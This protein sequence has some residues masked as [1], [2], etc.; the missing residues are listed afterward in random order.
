MEQLARLRSRIATVHELGQIIRAMRSLAAMRVQQAQAALPGIRKYAAIAGNAIVSVLPFAALPDVPRRAGGGRPRILVAFC[1]EHG[2][3]G[4][5]NDVLLARAARET[6]ARPTLLFLLGSRGADMADER[7]LKVDWRHAMATHA[8]GVLGVT[9]RLTP[10]LYR[11]LGDGGPLEVD[12]LFARYSAGAQW[13]VETLRLLPPD[14]SAFEAPR[15]QTPLHNLPAD[16]LVAKLVEEYVLAEL[17]RVAMESLA[18][19]NGARLRAMEE[20]NDNVAALIERLQRTEHQLRQDEITTE[21]LDVV[22]GTTAQTG[23]ET[24]A[25]V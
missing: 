23:I 22:T 10:A 20:A 8:G 2:F 13:T 6:A 12:L 17:T 25:A 14:L 9:R 11:A 1:A 19:E 5:F 16:A 24:G 4:D 21:L 7:G 15:R 18:S 3:V